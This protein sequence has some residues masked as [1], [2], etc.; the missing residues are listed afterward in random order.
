MG[1]PGGFE[2]TPPLAT[3]NRFSELQVA[4]IAGLS[5]ANVMTGVLIGYV[6]D[7]VGTDRDRFGSP[8]VGPVN[9]W[10]LVTP[11]VNRVQQ[12]SPV[13]SSHARIGLFCNRIKQ[14]IQ[15]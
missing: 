2:T 6:L 4:N 13:I 8:V 12:A 5:G 7:P 15:C 11:S 1:T 10:P 3:A 14:M 9:T